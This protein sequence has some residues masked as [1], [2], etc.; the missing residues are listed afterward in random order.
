MRGEQCTGRI[1]L[2]YKL[3]NFNWLQVCFKMI[4]LISQNGQKARKSE[5]WKMGFQV[6]GDQGFPRRTRLHGFIL[7]GCC[8]NWFCPKESRIGSG[9][10][11]S[12]IVWTYRWR[13]QQQKWSW[14]SIWTMWLFQP[15]GKS[16]E[17]PT[18]FETH[19]FTASW[20]CLTSWQPCVHW[21]NRL[22]KNYISHFY[23][24]REHR[25]VEFV[26]QSLSRKA[27]V[28]SRMPIE[29]R[30]K[31]LAGV[32]HRKQSLRS[33][34]LQSSPLWH[35]RIIEYHRILLSINLIA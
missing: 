7:S 12:F 15:S 9:G 5:S 11:V 31:R 4:L 13:L 24:L 19:G 8:A 23:Y 1:F 34:L 6:Q 10:K 22:E 2:K 29:E 33:F 16:F 18:L 28:A 17:I 32:F 3:M 25:G 35:N 30:Q 26:T 21:W 20:R 27:D 14:N